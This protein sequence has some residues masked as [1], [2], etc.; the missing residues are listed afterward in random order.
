MWKYKKKKREGEWTLE[1]KTFLHRWL[2]IKNVYFDKPRVSEFWYCGKWVL[3]V[4]LSSLKEVCDLCDDQISA[5]V[6]W[7]VLA[8]TQLV[9]Q[10]GFYS[11]NKKV[12]CSEDPFCNVVRHCQDTFN[13]CIWR[14]KVA[15]KDYIAVIAPC[16]IVAG[17]GN[18][19]DQF[20]FFFS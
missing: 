15:P 18:P 7:L 14:L 13:G 16:V 17:W 20:H 1:K 8:R 11:F 9:K 12:Y 2:W 5:P 4:F 6:T 19:L 10:K 3:F